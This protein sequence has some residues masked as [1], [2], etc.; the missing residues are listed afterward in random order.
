MAN[1]VT[2]KRLVGKTTDDMEMGVL[3]SLPHDLADIPA[4]IIAVRLGTIE[5]GASVL[6]KVESVK[7]FL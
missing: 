6:Q 4:D 7:P 5:M 1:A 2:G 3:D